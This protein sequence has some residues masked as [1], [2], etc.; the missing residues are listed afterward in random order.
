M[1]TQRS[2]LDQVQKIIQESLRLQRFQQQR[3][4]AL[5]KEK[6]EK[7]Q[8]DEEKKIHIRQLRH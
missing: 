3:D 2:Q 6:L 4:K 8:H 7:A 5:E 1:K